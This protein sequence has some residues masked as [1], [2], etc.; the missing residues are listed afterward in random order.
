[1]NLNNQQKL[2]LHTTF[3]KSISII[4]GFFCDA[5]SVGVRRA[6]PTHQSQDQLLAKITQMTINASK[7]FLLMVIETDIL[8]LSNSG[9]LVL[10]TT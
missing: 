7:L 9:L 4:S 6:T 1:M 8:V 2:L 10:I 3:Y 5:F